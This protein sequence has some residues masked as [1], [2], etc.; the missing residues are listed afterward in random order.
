MKGLYQITKALHDYLIALEDVNVIT[1]WDISKIDL[2]KQTIF[3]LVH[4]EIGDV[5]EDG[6]GNATLH[7]FTFFFLDRVDISMDDPRDIEQYY[8]GNNNLID[9]WHT[10]LQVVMRFKESMRRGDLWDELIQLDSWNASPIDEDRYANYLAGW[11]LS[12]A[13]KVPNSGYI[14]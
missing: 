5:S 14:C 10:M 8:W 3:P 9:V 13:I 6:S 11:T 12:F 4:M 2:N 1:G 7:N